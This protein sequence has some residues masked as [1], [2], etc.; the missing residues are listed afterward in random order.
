MHALVQLSP[1]VESGPIGSSLLSDYVMPA[2]CATLGYTGQPLARTF[3]CYPTSGRE[4]CGR[5]VGFEEAGI[6]STW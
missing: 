2:L 6:F 5:L 4:V 3:L 1:S